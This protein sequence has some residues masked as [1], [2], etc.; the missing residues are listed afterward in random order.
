[1]N[2]VVGAKKQEAVARIRA[3]SLDELLD[4]ARAEFG[5]VSF[6]TAFVGEGSVE[7]LQIQ[8]MPAYLDRLAAKSAPGSPVDLPFWAKVWPACLVLASFLARLPLPEDAVQ[9]EIGSGAG[10]SGLFAAKHGAS[11][12]ISDADPNA[13][14]FAQA[15]ILKNGLA[16][17]ASIAL[18]DFTR[19]RLGRRFDRIF[20]CET[21][22]RDM[23]YGP[24]VDFLL[25][26]LKPGPDHEVLLCQDSGRRGLSFLDKAKD[27]F[28]I[29]MKEI[30]YSGERPDEKSSVVLYRL[31][32]L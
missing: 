31:G 13:L 32:A 15:G 23:D 16:D 14:L 3:A 17:R 29:R 5:A 8:D 4:L 6:E 27:R 20:G 18:A 2:P 9:L 24:V 22:Y 25:A 21:F 11:V 19:D 1:V 12:V 7:I 26:H 28:R 30:A 10:L